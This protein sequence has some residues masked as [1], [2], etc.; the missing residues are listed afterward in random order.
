MICVRGTVENSRQMENFNGEEM[1]Q[2]KV[3]EWFH[4]YSW[5]T[6]QRRFVTF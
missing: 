2:R 1:V 6:S 3:T 5:L 4:L